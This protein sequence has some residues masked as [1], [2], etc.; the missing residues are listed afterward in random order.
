[1]CSCSNSKSNKVSDGGDGDGHPGMLH[2]LAQPLHHALALVLLGQGVPTLDD[3]EH[4]V[5]A[6]PDGDEG[7]DVVG[8]VV[9]HPKHEHD[10]KSCTKTEN[11][12]EHSGGRKIETNLGGDKKE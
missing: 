6:D 12:G 7:E 4:V 9:L 10:A 11:A 8:L 3:D 1:M 5:D 2:G